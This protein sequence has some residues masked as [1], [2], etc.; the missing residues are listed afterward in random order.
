MNK[1]ELLF[2]SITIFLT[3]IAWLIADIYQV[4]SQPKIK[5][6]I[7]LPEISTNYQIDKNILNT[8]KEKKP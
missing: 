7:K 1:K 5:A 3:A 8:L 2:I 6:I 4:S